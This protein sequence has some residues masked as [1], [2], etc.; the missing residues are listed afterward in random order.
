MQATHWKGGEGA[1]WASKHGP[2]KTSG[3][4]HSVGWGRIGACLE[5]SADP[6][7]TT[8]QGGGVLWVGPGVGGWG[9]GREGLNKVG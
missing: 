8:E 2:A 5:G 9:G 3:S 1:T 6:P 7:L 4:R